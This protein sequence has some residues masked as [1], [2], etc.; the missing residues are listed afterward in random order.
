MCGSKMVELWV[1]VVVVVDEERRAAAAKCRMKKKGEMEQLKSRSSSLA[2]ENKAL[3]KDMVIMKI[4]IIRLQSELTF[5]M[6]HS[7]C[8]R[9]EE[10]HRS[11]DD[12]SADLLAESAN[13][14]QD[15]STVD[16]AED[17]LLEYQSLLPPV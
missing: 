1:V 4:E 9:P 17:A 11:L 3:K 2:A 13:I 12:L 7:G 15:T 8:R 5:H 6:S 10:I 16:G 14:F